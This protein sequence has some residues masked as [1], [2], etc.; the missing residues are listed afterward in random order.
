LSAYGL[1]QFRGS[2]YGLVA[3]GYRHRLGSFP[4]LIRGRI[5]GAVWYEGGSAFFRRSDLKYRDD[6]A[7]AVVVDT[8]PRSSDYRWRVGQGRHRQDFLLGRP[9]FLGP[10]RGGI[11][12]GSE[13]PVSNG[14]MVTS[15]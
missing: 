10:A 13:L 6:V 7:G 1:A 15:Y 12:A 2:N 4:T 11:P 3:G 9:V 14:E 8:F 5:Y